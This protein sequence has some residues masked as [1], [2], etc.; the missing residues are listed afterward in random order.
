LAWLLLWI[1]ADCLLLAVGYFGLG[2]KVYGKNPRGGFPIWARVIHLPMMLSSLLVWQL[3]R[4]FSREN[5]YDEVAGGLFVGRRLSKD[6]IPAGMNYWI[7]LTAELEDP[8]QIRDS[9][10]YI[11][12]PILDGTVPDAAVL[13][14]ILSRLDHGKT[15]VHCAQGHGRAALFALALL[16][17]RG[18][19]RDV[20][21]GIRLLQK[22][23]PS[24]VLHLEQRKFVADFIERIGHQRKVG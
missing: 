19:I 4:L 21:E 15:Y 7:D 23:R 5:A 20:E 6:E 3:F 18:A 24:I 13:D 22:E 17:R 10:Q 14:H 2:P 1:S 12:L 11:C 16:A 8:K 9:T